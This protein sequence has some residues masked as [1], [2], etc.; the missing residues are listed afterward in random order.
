MFSYLRYKIN[1]I[2]KRQTITDSLDKF[3]LKNKKI[4]I[5]SNNC[6]NIGVYKN[7][8]LKFNTPFIGLA[9]YPKD[10]IK[11]ISNLEYYLKNPLQAE[12]FLHETEYV[13][14]RGNSYPVAI[15]H[16]VTIHFIHYKNALEAV[17]KWNRRCSRL[18]DFIQNN[19]IDDVI[20]KCCDMDFKE[21]DNIIKF[22][23]LRFRRKIYIQNRQ[24]SILLNRDGTFPDGIQLY[25]IRILY[26]L[27]FLYL[28][29][30][31]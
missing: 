25:K 9:I 2:A 26:Y 20:F 24:N 14:N 7:L 13:D 31:L 23:E 27:K 5:V 16:G 28:F 3:F 6:W 17:E 19:S 15:L 8:N 11:L 12:H 10:F 4:A 18:L 21:Q 29:K 1:K 22:N 30:G